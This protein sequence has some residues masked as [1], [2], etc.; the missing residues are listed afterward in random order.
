MTTAKLSQHGADRIKETLAGA[1]LAMPLTLK[2]GME[3][4]SLKLWSVTSIT[5]SMAFQMEI[6][7]WEKK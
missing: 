5:F 7:F 1:H 2:W 4:S 3:S 6:H